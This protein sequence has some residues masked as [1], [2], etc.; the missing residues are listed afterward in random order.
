MNGSRSSRAWI[1]R[2]A[3]DQSALRSDICCTRCR[4]VERG[5]SH[6]IQQRSRIGSRKQYR[7][8]RLFKLA[9]A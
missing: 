9:G 6:V 8:A 7:V 4:K 1:R 2:D 5:L 3:A